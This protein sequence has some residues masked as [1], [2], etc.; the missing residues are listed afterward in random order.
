[1]T[2]KAAAKNCAKVTTLSILTG[3][4]FSFLLISIQKNVIF[5]PLKLRVIYKFGTTFVWTAKK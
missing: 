5:V 3:H 2:A 4:L 1:M